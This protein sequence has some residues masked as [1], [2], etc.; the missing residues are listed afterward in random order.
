[1][2]SVLLSAAGVSAEE[3][4]IVSAIDGCPT[5]T[6]P[7]I[8]E[9]LRGVP[10]VIE[11]TVECE[12]GTLKEVLLQ[13]RLTDLG[14][15]KSFKMKDEG[16]GRYKANIPVSMIEGLPRFWYY[17]DANGV[18]TNGEPTRAQTSWH[19][20]HI[21]DPI[22][23]GGAA[24]FPTTK[25]GFYWLAGGVAALGGALVI[26]NNTHN[27]N[28]QP[29]GAQVSSD[30][31]N[32]GASSPQRSRAPLS[33]SSE[34]PLQASSPSSPPTPSSCDLTPDVSFA[35]TSPCDSA[36]LEVYVCGVCPGAGISVL[37]SWG[38]HDSALVSS[39]VV[40]DVNSPVKLTVAKPEDDSGEVGGF[41]SGRGRSRGLQAALS[42]ESEWIQVWVGSDLV[43][44]IVWPSSAEYY[45]CISVDN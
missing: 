44:Q 38:E 5:I 43:E 18:S 20:V 33:P 21:L 27:H 32:E 25:S 8:F 23:P 19:V 15:P 13:L 37:T 24:L 36:D 28:A 4:E 45:D 3:K 42:P 14:K 29:A 26:D 2:L 34:E 31:Q 7:P 6:H 12:I 30:S 17:I 40:C 35:R 39:E 1:M 10:V 9:V 41:V 16:N 11:A 22:R